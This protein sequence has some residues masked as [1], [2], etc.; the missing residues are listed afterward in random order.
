[1]RALGGN[2]LSRQ[3]HRLYIY[4]Y[5]HIFYKDASTLHMY[6]YIYIKE[7]KHIDDLLSTPALNCT[8]Y[9][10]LYCFASYKVAQ[11]FRPNG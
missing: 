11:D 9:L 10:V 4:I 8:K 2:Y 3:Y 7:G 6:I 5:I 1:M